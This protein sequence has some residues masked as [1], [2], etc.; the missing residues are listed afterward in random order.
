[1]PIGFREWT[2]KDLPAL[3]VLERSCFDD[4]WTMEM[5]RAELGKSESYGL[6]LEEDG[7]A[8]GYACGTVLFEDAE[9]EKVAVVKER[10]GKGYGKALVNALLTLAESK[11][12][13]RVFLE[14]RASN[15]PALGLY[16]GAGFEKTRLRK[17]YYEDGEDALEMKKELYPEEE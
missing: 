3:A 7:K 2:E 12:A 10:R 6:L 5:L 16:Q 8:I 4:P 9:I 1:M 17:R 11:G 15:A 13:Q 14:V